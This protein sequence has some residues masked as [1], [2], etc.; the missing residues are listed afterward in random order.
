[1]ES[2]DGGVI[3]R[4][5]RW[6]VDGLLAGADTIELGKLHKA[7]HALAVST[8]KMLHLYQTL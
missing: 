1:M 4:G 7:R 3:G 8:I 5:A 6:F 2:A